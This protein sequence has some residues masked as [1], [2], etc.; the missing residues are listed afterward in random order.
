[1]EDI[2]VGLDIGT[3]KTCAVI[4]FL[5]ENNQ[6]EVAGVGVAPSK[7]LKNG[8]IVNIEN[9]SASIVKAIENA[10]TSAGYEVSSVFVGVSGQHI[11][12]ENSKGVVAITNRNRTITQSEVKR[13]IEAAQAIVI[14]VDREIMHVLSKEF[15]VDDQSG[16]KDPVGMSAVRLE[17]EVHII[18]A[19]TA[20]IQNMIKAVAKA[21]F[22]HRD[23]VFNALAS[24]DA[25][26]SKDEKEL[27][28]ALIDIGGGTTDIIVYMEGGVAYS[29]VLPVGSIHIT[30]DISIGLRTS[31]ESAEMIKKK[32]GCADLSLVDASEIVEVPSVGGRA[33]RRL[34]RQ[35]LTQIIQPR[36]AEIMEMVD[37]E[38]L[39]SGKKDM[40]SAG[41]VLTGGGS[42]LEGCIEAAERVFAMP[43]RIG[44]PL[45]IVGGLKDEVSTPQYANGVGL[46]KYGIRMSQFR[47][48]GRFGRSKESF[49][50]KIKRGFT[51]YF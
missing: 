46:L 38:L 5:N 12:G 50:D 10:E 23:I 37:H 27:G 17:A 43:V 47:S 45:D 32:Y 49:L 48:Q 11:K 2:I 1:M 19:A 51:Q 29:A 25:V 9:T 30:N 18:T 16:I 28:V 22:Q 15:T 6:V 4:G 41:I 40:L 13:V 39:K 31:I 7:G 34:F 35:E 26:L 20:S 33:P 36:V 44:L 3:T 14:P 42:M 21:G 24:A 8:V